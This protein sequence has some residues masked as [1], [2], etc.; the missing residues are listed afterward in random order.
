MKS[1]STVFFPAE[2]MM[3][4]YMALDVSLKTMYSGQWS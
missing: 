2:M 3:N 1:C 4:S